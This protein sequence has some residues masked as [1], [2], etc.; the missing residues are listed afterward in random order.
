MARAKTTAPLYEPSVGPVVTLFLLLSPNRVR[1]DSVLLN[2][3]FCMQDGGRR[4]VDYLFNAPV[5]PHSQPPTLSHGDYS[6][7]PAG[8]S[9]K[10]QLR[11]SNYSLLLWAFATH[12]CVQRCNWFVSTGLFHGK[13]GC[14]TF[15]FLKGGQLHIIHMEKYPYQCKALIQFVKLMI[16]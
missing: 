14:S 13:R 12:L 7:S 8:Y 1:L 10:Y 4:R 3:S 6:S 16:P 11:V 5:Q 2:A 15:T 9:S